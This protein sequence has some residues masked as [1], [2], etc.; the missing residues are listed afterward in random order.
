MFVEEEL[1]YIYKIC[2]ILFLLILTRGQFTAIIPVLILTVAYLI[3]KN[4]TIAKNYKFLIILIALPFITSL[5]EK[6]YNKVVFGYYV[7][8]AMNYVHLI[9]SP[10]YIANEDDINLFD[11]EDEKTY[12]KL[13]YDSLYEAELTRDQNLSFETDDYQFYQQNFTK[14]CNKRIYK[15]GLEFF[16]LKELNYYEQNISLNKL[17]SKMVFPLIK[18][19]FKI[20]SILVFKNLKN[21]FSSFK[22]LLMFLMLFAYG[23]FYLRKRNNNTYKFIVLAILFML[24]NNMLIALV[25]HSI[26]RYIFYF[27]WVIFAVIILLFNEVLKKNTTH[28]F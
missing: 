23:L 24:A 3:F 17:C 5:T 8:N 12:F 21:S 2:A 4:K 19:N 9:S 15:L 28:E 18:Q 27:D 6:V 11:E 13:I 1:S 16:E 20:W 26:K 22:Q 10:F 14:I 25:V 7:N